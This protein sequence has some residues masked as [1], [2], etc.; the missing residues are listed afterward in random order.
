MRAVAD[1]NMPTPQISRPAALDLEFQTADMAEVATWARGAERTGTREVRIEGDNLLHL[2]ESFVAV[3]Y[4][5]R[6]AGGR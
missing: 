3:N 1:K 6:Q 4:I 2:F 5:T